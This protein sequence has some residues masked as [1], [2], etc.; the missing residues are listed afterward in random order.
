MSK[1][2]QIFQT[3]RLSYLL[4][5]ANGLESR[6]HYDDARALL[7]NVAV[8]EQILALRDAYLLKLAWLSFTGRVLDKGFGV[9][10]LSEMQRLIYE[11]QTQRWYKDPTAENEEYA[12]RYV[13]LLEAATLA[14]GERVNELAESLRGLKASAPFKAHLP[15]P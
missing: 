13:D 10:P 7:Q 5:R 11:A 4:Y 2:R 6:G 8:P 3:A 15:I 12:A 1:L 9:H 14:G